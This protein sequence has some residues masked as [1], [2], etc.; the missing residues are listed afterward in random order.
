MIAQ[1]VVAHEERIGALLRRQ[2]QVDRGVVVFVGIGP[3]VL[4]AMVAGWRQ[5]VGGARV[6]RQVV[7]TREGAGKGGVR[8]TAQLDVAIRCRGGSSD[9]YGRRT[10]CGRAQAV[11]AGAGQRIPGERAV[12]SLHAVGLVV[13]HA[14]HDAALVGRLA[15]REGVALLLAVVVVGLTKVRRELGALVILAQDEVDHAADRVGTVDRGRA[16]GQHVDMIDH[17]GGNRI[18][19]HGAADGIA[20]DPMTVDQDQRAIRPQAAQSNA[21]GAGT[22]AVV[23]LRVGVAT[24]DGRQILHQVTQGQLAAGL[25][26]CAIDGH[27]RAGRF[28]IHAANVRTG[29][30]DRLQGRCFSRL[31]SIAGARRQRCRL[32]LSKCGARGTYRDDSP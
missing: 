7:A 24:G 19:I 13:V 8:R 20:D 3:A 4:E 23:D 2:D 27:D 32:I 17:R 6:V 25:D 30:H 18:R 31:G 28:Q 16:G 1:V 11:R 21:A 12:A 29:H 22:A 9:V 26:G 10:R 15:K 14:A 5:R